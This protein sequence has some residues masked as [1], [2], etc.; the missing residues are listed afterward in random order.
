MHTFENGRFAAQERR[1]RYHRRKQRIAFGRMIIAQREMTEPRRENQAS[2]STQ[3]S[4]KQRP[5]AYEFDVER[6]RLVL[7]AL[8]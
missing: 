2:Q 8:F 6:Q 4:R 1:H 7:A 5:R 3:Q